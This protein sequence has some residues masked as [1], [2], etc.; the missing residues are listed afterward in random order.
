VLRN[1]YIPALPA[2]EPEH[3][4]LCFRLSY[5]AR[6]RPS[7]AALVAPARAAPDVTQ[8]SCSSSSCCCCCCCR[9]SCCSPSRLLLLLLQS[10][11]DKYLEPAKSLREAAHRAWLPI[12]SSRSL[13]FNRR[14]LKA[15]ALEDITQQQV[16]EWYGTHVNP[17]GS[18]HHAMCVQVWGGAAGVPDGVVAA[19]HAA[20]GGGGGGSVV[21][22]AGDV[23]AFKKAQALLPLPAMQLPPAA[24]AA[25]AAAHN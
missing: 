1:H 7:T 10:L 13:V 17:T 16:M 21:V 14:Q 12:G 18:H 25:A 23:V 8:L 20:A 4:C 15:A 24:A 6:S 3:A 11:L 22:A 5:T 19:L 9:C 2:S